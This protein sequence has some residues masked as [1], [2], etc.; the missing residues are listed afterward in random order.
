M[1]SGELVWEAEGSAMG[2]IG[3]VDI[4]EE[5]VAMG[6]WGWKPIL[7]DIPFLLLGLT[8]TSF[9]QLKPNFKPSEECLDIEIEG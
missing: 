4:E 1:G 8:I 2:R 5:E 3:S 9:Y 6:P 7:E